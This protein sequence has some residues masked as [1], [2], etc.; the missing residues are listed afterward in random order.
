MLLGFEL[1]FL[2]RCSTI[3]LLYH[4]VLGLV[5][6]LSANDK[7][8]FTMKCICFVE[9]QWFIIEQVHGFA[10]CLV[11][12]DKITKLRWDIPHIFWAI[13][14]NAGILR[15]NRRKIFLPPSFWLPTQ[16]SVN[17]SINIA[18]YYIKIPIPLV[19]NLTARLKASLNWQHNNK[20][21]MATINNWCM[22]NEI[23]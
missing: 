1:W 22:I 17:K 10:I 21:M 2:K 3:H 7:N 6:F 5:S 19:D 18:V 13:V 11:L 16:S 15:N 23:I 20:K 8:S 9:I 4:D 12:V 14:L